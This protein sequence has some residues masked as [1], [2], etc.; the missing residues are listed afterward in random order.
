MDMPFG[1]WAVR[2]W[3]VYRF[4]LL[5]VVGRGVDIIALVGCHIA[6]VSQ[7]HIFAGC[8]VLCGAISACIQSLPGYILDDPEALHAMQ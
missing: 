8:S 4:G 2:R 3:R 6:L 1:S 5:V 7:S